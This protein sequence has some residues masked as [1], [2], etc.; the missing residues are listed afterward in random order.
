M[1]HSWF[2]LFIF[3]VTIGSFLNVLS[4]RYDS[5]GR[6]FTSRV[7]GGRSRCETCGEDLRWFE[8]IPFVS[9]IIQRGK[10][11]RC[12]A[13][14]SFQYPIIELLSGAALA[15]IPYVVASTYG[16]GLAFRVGSELPVSYYA[17]TALFAIALFVYLFIAAVDARLTI[18]PDQSNVLLVLLGI[19][20]IGIDMFS[21]TWGDFS[22]SFIGHYAPLFGLREN[23]WLN[24]GAAAVFGGLFFGAIFLLSRGRAMGFGDVKLA[25]ATGVLLGWPDTALALTIAFIVGAFF[26]ILL[27]VRRLKGMK[28]SIP[29]GPFIVVGVLLVIFF[30]ERIMDGYFALFP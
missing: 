16:V 10:C 21:G 20:R 14:L 25:A 26:G 27:M 2:L 22:G 7:F 29:F 6:I 17:T 30:G 24:H 11:R 18:I 28:S 1:A 15:G 4:R 5:E 12:G 13:Q 23:I 9:F 8:L 19:G 3:G